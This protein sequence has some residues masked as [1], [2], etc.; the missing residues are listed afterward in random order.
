MIYADLLKKSLMGETEPHTGVELHALSSAAKPFCT[1]IVRDAIQDCREST[2]GHGYLK[3]LHLICRK[4]QIIYMHCIFV[5]VARIGDCRNAN[6]PNCTYEG[7]NNVLIQQTSNWLLSIRR[8]GYHQFK[9][10]SPLKT[11]DV[12]ANFESIIKQKA[13]WTSAGD[14]VD[15]KSNENNTQSITF[16]SYCF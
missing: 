7:E 5:L 2:G 8:G 3:G 6:D 11:A 1:W 10:R 13:T 12:L 9:E 16:I 4:A 14:A 15:P